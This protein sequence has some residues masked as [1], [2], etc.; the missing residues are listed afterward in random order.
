MERTGVV[1]FKGNPLTLL[2]TEQKVG[3]MAP[4][5][6]VLGRDLKPVSLKDFQGSAK[7]ISVTPSLDTPVCDQQARRFNEVAAK[8]PEG[9][10]IMN[11]SMDLPFAINR[12]CTAAGIE[13][14]KTFSDHRDAS[15]GTNYGVLVKELRLLARAIFLIDADNTIR[16]MEVVPEMTNNVNFEKSLEA[17]NRLLVRR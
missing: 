11:I 13:R 6:T 9:I 4:D 7:L 17:A 5:F 15:F 3:N 16:Y 10:S 8:L 12:F 14:I 1:T 2:G